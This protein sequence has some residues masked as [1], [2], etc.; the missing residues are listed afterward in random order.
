MFWTEDTISSPS[1][2]TPRPLTLSLLYVKTP[3]LNPP[4]VDL[5]EPGTDLIYVPGR[6]A[7]RIPE[8]D[9]QPYGADVM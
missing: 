5:Y 6:L 2:A 1:L 4:R 8:T 9:G 7:S 3:N